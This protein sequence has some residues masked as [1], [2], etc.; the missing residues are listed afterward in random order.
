MSLVDNLYLV[1]NEDSSPIEFAYARNSIVIEAGKHA[2][3]PFEAIVEKLGDPRSGPTT[4]KI[5]VDGRDVGRIASRSWWLKRLA[6]YYGTYD[7]TDVVGLKAIMPKV[8]VTTLEGDDPKFSFPV[9]DPDCKYL[10]PST[11][12]GVS[13]DENL[14]RELESMKRRMRATEKLLAEKGIPEPAENIPEDVPPANIASARGQ[15]SSL[16][17]K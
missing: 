5:I 4:Q 10:S 6:T 14:R 12:T 2:M 15:A 8:S 17:K 11:N 16:L 7:P 3:V 1:T 13:D 9:D